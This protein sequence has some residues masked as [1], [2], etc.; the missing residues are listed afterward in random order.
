M[1]KGIE[2]LVWDV[3]RPRSEPRGAGHTISVNVARRRTAVRV[4]DGDTVTIPLGE[5]AQRK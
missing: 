2:G 1:D 4:A 3:V 5:S